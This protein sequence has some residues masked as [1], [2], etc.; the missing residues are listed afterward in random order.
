MR[1]RRVRILNLYQNCYFNWITFLLLYFQSVTNNNSWNPIWNSERYKTKCLEL[2][3]CSEFATKKRRHPVNG[4]TWDFLHYHFDRLFGHVVHVFD[5][6]STPIET[7][8]KNVHLSD[9]DNIMYCYNIIPSAG[10]IPHVPGNDAVPLINR[11][12]PYPYPIPNATRVRVIYI[13]NKTLPS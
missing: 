4:S 7:H 5:V 13:R 6:F 12:I 9:D 1:L 8:G 11:T 10:R 3:Y 2:P